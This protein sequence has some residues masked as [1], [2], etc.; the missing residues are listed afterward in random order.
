MNSN[1]LKM[2][3]IFH[4]IV[5]NVT[6]PDYLKIPASFLYGTGFHFLHSCSLLECFAQNILRGGINVENVG[7]FG[8]NSRNKKGSKI[9]A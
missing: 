4:Q 5:L 3:I 8:A 1:C 2:S 9:G 6:L 7:M